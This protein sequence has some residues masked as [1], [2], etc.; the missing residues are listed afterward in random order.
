MRF[1]IGKK[2]EKW[3]SNTMKSERCE[4]KER[5]MPDQ[6]FCYLGSN[7]I[8]IEPLFE[9]NNRNMTC[10]RSQI[11]NDS[12]RT[13]KVVPC[14]PIQRA[15]ERERGWLNE[16]KSEEKAKKKKKKKKPKKH[17]F[18]NKLYCELRKVNT[19]PEMLFALLSHDH[20]NATHFC[21]YV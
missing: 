17:F 2:R 7:K 13:V 6:V 5:K 10:I 21:K 20:F 11:K 3:S 19:E 12:T 4:S 14:L 15:R 1:F 18:H 8:D 9:L 16:E